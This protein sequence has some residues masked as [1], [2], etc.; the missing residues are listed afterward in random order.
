MNLGCLY[1]VYRQG[2]GRP[3]LVTER[4]DGDGFLL[5]EMGSLS[6]RECC[7]VKVIH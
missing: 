3:D 4:E 2:G 5:T 6:L 7:E 1:R